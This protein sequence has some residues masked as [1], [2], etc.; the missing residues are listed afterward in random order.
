MRFPLNIERFDELLEYLRR[1]GRLGDVETPKV[2]GLPGGVSNRTVLVEPR[3]G[4]AFVIKQALGKL[5]VEAD[6][7]SDPGRSHCEALGLTWLAR[8]AP[9]GTIPAL[10]FE[11]EVHHL[12]A[13][14]AVPE[15][16]ENWKPL[17]LAGRIE[18]RHVEQF[19]QLLGTIQCRAREHVKQLASVFEN[20]TFFESLRLEPYYSYAASRNP[21]A[22]E[23]FQELI[24]DTLATRVNLVHGDYSPKNILVHGNTLVLLDHEVI[25]WGD[26]AFD[27]GFSLTHLLSKANHL[28]SRRAAFLRAAVHFWKTYQGSAGP[29]PEPKAFEARVARHTLGCLLARVDG[30]SP[31]EYLSE[32]ARHRQRTAVLNMIPTPPSSV[33]ELVQRFEQR[34][35]T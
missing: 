10:V 18:L 2:T 28:P 16:H 29:L 34:L 22:A 20:R 24:S 17:L 23:F 21:A 7:R 27:V 31:L 9:P 6:W 3:Q 19:A 15:P 30:R 33:L 11:D 26:P 4:H 12:V 35:A 14:E 1:T 25:H 5:R 8:L 32:A 13:M